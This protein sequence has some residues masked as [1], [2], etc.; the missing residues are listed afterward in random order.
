MDSLVANQLGNVASQPA[1]TG[2][3]KRGKMNVK[4]YLVLVPTEGEGVRV[5]DAKLTWSAADTL[6][7]DIEGAY[8]QKF[9]A[10]K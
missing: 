1:D 9:V 7:S 10:T 3:E 8:T 4:V 5:V 6:A 2:S